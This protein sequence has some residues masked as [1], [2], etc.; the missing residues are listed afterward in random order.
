MLLI[1]AHHYVVNSGLL[2]DG[3]PIKAELFSAK[4]FFLI[5]FGAFGKTG[6]NCFV[7][8]TGYFMCKSQITLKKFLKLICEV[9]FYN[10][11]IW[12]I[13]ILTGYEKFSF[14]ELIKKV[15][16]FYDISSGFTSCYI[17]FFLFIPFLNILLNN[18]NEKQHIK[19]I[20]LSFG[21]YT[22]MASIPKFSITFN[23]VTWFIILYFIS[24]YVR[25][26]DKKIFNN[27]KL[28][29]FLA[30]AVL[31]ISILSV[32][33]L[34][35]ISE[36]SGSFKAF[37]FLA[38]SNMIL[39]VLLAFTSFMFFKNLN[40]KHSK[41]INAVGGTTFGV[42]LIHA[43]S[44][45][46]R[47][48]LWQDVLDNVSYYD[49]KFMVLHAVGSVIGIFIICSAIDYLRIKFIEKPFF[50]RFDK[51]L[52][53]LTESYVKFESKMLKALNIK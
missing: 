46:M 41:F 21:V 16:P 36:K 23:Y 14:A 13:F 2:Y 35:F 47:K 8:I 22:V 43:S 9:E 7:L 12:L 33:V 24:A 28:W 17:I 11:S 45:A 52:N 29:G 48:W 51:F 31:I 32:A 38:D 4:S 27:C 18:M 34:T 15:F 26:Y 37:Y 49:S 30:L 3:G 44:N 25:L 20:A 42:L 39:A 19:L 50:N 5:I 40:V 1:V 10:I 53:K 6:I